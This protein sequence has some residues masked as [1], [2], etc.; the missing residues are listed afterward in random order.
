VLLPQGEERDVVHMPN[1]PRNRLLAGLSEDDSALLT[2]HLES[3]SVE[4]RH[5]IEEINKPIK[6]IYFMEEGI[7]S[8]V[9]TGGGDKEIEVG[10]IGREGMS[11]IAVVMGNH[12]AP[13]KVY[14]QVRG[15]AQRL[16]VAA[17]REALETSATLRPFLLKFAQTFM[18]QTT[19]TAIANG[20]ANL[21]QRLARWLLMAR[22]RLDGDELPLTHEFLA[23][24]LA[25]RRPGVTEAVQKLEERG[26]IGA[27]RGKILLRD[28]K[29]LEK[30]AGGFYGVPE[31]ELK[32]L[33]N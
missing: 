1:P 20:R 4:V 7:A 16:D 26:L 12:R 10:L 3:I 31:A 6:Q 32:R 33:L 24:M 9:A 2:P 23:L 29:G 28:R 18:L 13:H 19:H 17:L 30:V 5:P 8:V 22:D 14:V 15:H 25:V 11:G 27:G 21:E